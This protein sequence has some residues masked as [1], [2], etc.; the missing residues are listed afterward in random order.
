MPVSDRGFVTL[1]SFLSL[2]FHNVMKVTVT[3]VKVEAVEALVELIYKGKCKLEQ[4]F[5]YIVAKALLPRF[6]QYLGITTY[7]CLS[8]RSRLQD[9]SWALRDRMD[10]SWSQ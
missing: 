7:R 4:V 8:M 6:L 5:P 9:V 1:V 10:W 3:G 2:Y